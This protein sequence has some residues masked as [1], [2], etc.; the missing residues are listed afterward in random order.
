MACSTRVDR[1]DLRA[2]RLQGYGRNLT[3]D[4]QHAATLD[5]VNCLVW[6]PKLR[7]PGVT[8]RGRRTLGRLMAGA[9]A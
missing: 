6:G 1:P 8:A 5:A 9:F 4:E 2:A 7:G 3:P